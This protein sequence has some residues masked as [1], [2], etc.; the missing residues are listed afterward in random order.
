MVWRYLPKPIGR[1]FGV[2]AELLFALT[3]R[4]F[5]VLA[6]NPAHIEAHIIAVISAAGCFYGFLQIRRRRDPRLVMNWMELAFLVST[7]VISFHHSG[8]LA[9][10]M[11]SLPAVAGISALYLEGNMRRITLALGIVVVAFGFLTASGAVGIPTT[12]T[13]QN[14]AFMTMLATLFSAM[15][16]FGGYLVGVRFIGVDD[17]SFWSQMQAAVDVRQDV[18]NGVIK[19]VVFGIA[20]TWIA[21]FEGY[22]AP[23]TAEGVSRATTRT[24][25]SSSLAVLALD[26]VLTALMFRGI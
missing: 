19:S 23:P 6:L 25:V 13:P 10:I 12:Y 17:G 26:F 11:A 5:G 16:I 1:G 21:V 2:V 7:A 20:I 24:V 15:G 18:L 14:R 3:Q 4:F 9:P 8:I 22:D